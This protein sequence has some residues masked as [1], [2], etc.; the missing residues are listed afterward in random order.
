[1][2]LAGLLASGAFAGIATA[3]TVAA[4]QQRWSPSAL[5]LP[6]SPRRRGQRDAAAAAS[7]SAASA[8]V[9]SC[10]VGIAA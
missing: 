7:L 4:C 3:S 10:S 9:V 8:S 1:V 2:L 6:R 5:G